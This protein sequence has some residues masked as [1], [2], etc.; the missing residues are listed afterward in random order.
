MLRFHWLKSLF[1]GR[2]WLS[3]GFQT[4]EVPTKDPMETRSDERSNREKRIRVS[5][6]PLQQRLLEKAIPGKSSSR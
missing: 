3:F 4:L 5:K 1:G 2:V 6:V